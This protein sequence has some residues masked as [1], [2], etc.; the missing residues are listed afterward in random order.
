LSGFLLRTALLKYR[1][2]GRKKKKEKK[3]RKNSDASVA[4]KAC[5][6]L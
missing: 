3:E 4:A 6:F 1:K 2:R 5:N